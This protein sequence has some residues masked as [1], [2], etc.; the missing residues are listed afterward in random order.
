MAFFILDSDKE[1]EREGE[2]LR[3]KER[4]REKKREKYL[5]GGSTKHRAPEQS[6]L[7]SAMRSERQRRQASCERRDHGFG[8]LCIG[9]G[10][11]LG[12]LYI[13]FFFF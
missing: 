4:V 7:Q 8:L 3:E 10:F 9:F 12:L 6:D 13:G 1:R 2:R 5:E 11:G